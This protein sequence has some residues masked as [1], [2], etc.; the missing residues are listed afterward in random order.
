MQWADIFSNRNNTKCWKEP[1]I[2]SRGRETAQGLIFVAPLNQILLI[3]S[4]IEHAYKRSMY[5]Q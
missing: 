3:K 2:T 1:L 5:R 4:R